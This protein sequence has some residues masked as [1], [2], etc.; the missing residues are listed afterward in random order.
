MVAF[1]YLYRK[2]FSFNIVW[3]EILELNFSKPF[4]VWT[5]CVQSVRWKWILKWLHFCMD[6]V[7][8]HLKIKK[9]LLFTKSKR[10]NLMLFFI[11]GPFIII[12]FD[13]KILRQFFHTE[14][15]AF[16]NICFD[17]VEF[18]FIVHSKGNK[19]HVHSVFDS[20]WIVNILWK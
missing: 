6:I 3:I 1:D 10:N 17:W 14:P 19:G 5:N 20:N 4:H 11:W 12:N 7:F 18:G 15:V 8:T 16:K 2:W 9:V 13:F